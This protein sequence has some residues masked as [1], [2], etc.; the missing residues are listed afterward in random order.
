[1]R[2]GRKRCAF[3]DMQDKTIR[4]KDLAAGRIYWKAKVI[5]MRT[6]FY[7]LFFCW[8]N[9]IRGETTGS[10]AGKNKGSG[11]CVFCAAVATIWF[12]FANWVT[13]ADI[14]D[15]VLLKWANYLLEGVCVV[16]DG[17]GLFGAVW[18]MS[19]EGRFYPGRLGWRYLLRWLSQEE[20][21]KRVLV[22]T[23][24]VV[25]SLSLEAAPPIEGGVSLYFLPRT[26]QCIIIF[27]ALIVIIK[28]TAVSKHWPYYNGQTKHRLI[29]EVLTWMRCN[30]RSWP[31]QTVL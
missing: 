22:L 5:E 15:A 25:D 2:R 24:R 16:L 12:W 18:E 29:D 30:R 3:G 26:V 9:V 28:R 7:Q 19:R 31:A 21:L 20:L 14:S 4:R 23:R 8:S 17:C 27:I 10:K 6:N 11:K 1:M 13:E